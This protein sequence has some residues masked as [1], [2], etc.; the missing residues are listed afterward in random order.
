MRVTVIL[1]IVLGC[2]ASSTVHLQA[3]WLGDGT[4]MPSGGTEVCDSGCALGPWSNGCDC[5]SCLAGCGVV[6]PYCRLLPSDGRLKI[7]GWLNGGY[8]GNTSSPNSKFNGPYNAVAVPMSRCSIRAIWWAKSDCRG[9]AVGAWVV[10]LA[11]Y[12]HNSPA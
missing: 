5:D 4:G 10:G 6:D 7:Y 12:S 1:G 9:T 8:I 11:T 3:G 2:I